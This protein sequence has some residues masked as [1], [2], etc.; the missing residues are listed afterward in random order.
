MK[1]S[2]LWV[3]VLLLWFSGCTIKTYETSEPKII[4][5]KTKKLRFN[6]LGYIRQN[7]DALQVELFS[8]GQAVER[9]EINHLVCLSDGCMSKSG[10][11]SDYLNAEY[12]DDTLQNILLG[13]NIFDGKAMSETDSGFEQYLESES[14][15]ITYRVTAEEIY[16]KDKPNKILI[17]IKAVKK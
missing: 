13:R 8:A 14:Y 17:R 16:F 5:F 10:F 2:I 11:N 4:T 1:F 6:D 12:P 3:S 7:G 9:F 15:E